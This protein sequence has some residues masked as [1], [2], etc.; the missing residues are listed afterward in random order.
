MKGLAINTQ[1]GIKI[2]ENKI[3]IQN[4]SESGLETLGETKR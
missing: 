3:S 4:V 1:Q 2:S